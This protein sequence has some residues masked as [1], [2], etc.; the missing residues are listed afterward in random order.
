[1]AIL[2]GLLFAG[3]FVL[4]GLDYGAALVSR[5]RADLDRVAPFFLGN[6]V[7]L[8][9]ATGF[10][11]GA[12]PANEGELFTEHHW[13]V[14]LGLAGA[15]IVVAVFGMRLFNRG[16]GLDIV[17]K[18]GGLLAAIGWG[19]ALGGV[20]GAGGLWLAGAIAFPLLLAAHGWAF[21]RRKWTV[22]ALTTVAITAGVVL[23]G[24]RIDWHA[25]PDATLAVVAPTAWVLVP[26]L[27]AVQAFSWWLLRPV[28]ADP[29]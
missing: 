24:A 14:G 29:R 1:M 12:Y 16:P 20:A 7:W 26:L 19:A 15:V 22:L 5:G 6:E 4:G 18:A 9:A 17:A 8:V 25:A 23:V 28:V 10:L 11:L 27:V 21:L 3:Y 2:L 13:A